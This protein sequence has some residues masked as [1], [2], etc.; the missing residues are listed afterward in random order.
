MGRRGGGDGRVGEAA[1]LRPIRWPVGLPGWMVLGRFRVWGK[2]GWGGSIARL[3][4]C[5]GVY[6]FWTVTEPISRD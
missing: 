4:G 5:L 6:Y 1:G 3:V 2:G